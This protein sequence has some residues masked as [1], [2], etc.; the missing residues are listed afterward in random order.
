MM[1]HKIA[2][3]HNLHVVPRPPRLFVVASDIKASFFF[4]Y[5]AMTNNW[6]CLGMRVYEDGFM[7][8]RAL[9]V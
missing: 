7:I 3:A 5:E 2:K 6:E 1:S 4:T 9:A 8:T